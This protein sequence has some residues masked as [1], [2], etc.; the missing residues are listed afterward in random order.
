MAIYENHGHVR[1]LENNQEIA[2]KYLE[3]EAVGSATVLC[4]T[5]KECAEIN[6]EIRELRRA[7]GK[8]GEDLIKIENRNFAVNDQVIFTENS[9]IFDVKNGQ[10]GV[11]KSFEN[12][13]LN[14][15][16]EAGMRKI[17]IENYNK[18]DHGY[19]ITLHKSQGKTYDN[20]IVLANKMMDAK[21]A[22]VAMTRHRENVDFYYRKSDFANFKQLADSVSRYSYKESLEDFK[23]IENQNKARVFEY[24]ELQI[25]KALLLKE[26]HAGTANWAECRRFTFKSAEAE[27]R[28][29]E[30]GKALAFQSESTI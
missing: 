25:E 23:N 22:Y 21:A 8:L 1:E 2:Q 3:I 18:I 15:E 26:I 13:F 29:T 27:G 5:R 11:V 6:A 17:D 16:T 28:A 12:G 14:I 19:A 10:T 30:E 20:T 4:S 7:C 24:K 9:K